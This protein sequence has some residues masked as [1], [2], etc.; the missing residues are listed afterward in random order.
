MSPYGT[1]L[2]CPLEECDWKLRTDLGALPVRYVVA[3][4]TPEGISAAISQ[5]ARKRAEMTE[6]VIRQHLGTHDPIDYLRTIVTL[7]QRLGQYEPV[8][9]IV[10]SNWPGRTR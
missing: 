2:V 7:R 9:D 8:P 10:E 6:E 5:V 3:D 1:Y 4:L